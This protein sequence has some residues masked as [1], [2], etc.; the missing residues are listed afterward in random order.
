MKKFHR[1]LS[2]RSACANI[3]IKAKSLV[4][5]NVHPTNYY[6][7]KI[8]LIDRFYY[9]SRIIERLNACVSPCLTRVIT[10][11]QHDSYTWLLVLFLMPVISCWRFDFSNRFFCGAAQGSVVRLAS[12]DFIKVNHCLRLAAFIPA[13]N[14]TCQ[15]GRCQ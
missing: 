5:N 9:G 11:G 10:T 4:S 1:P 12:H 15:A 13:F 14:W 7:A 3:F 2:F 6:P 8:A